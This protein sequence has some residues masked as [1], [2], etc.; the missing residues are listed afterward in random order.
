MNRGEDRKEV[1]IALVILCYKGGEKVREFVKMTQRL[2]SSRNLTYQ[3]V[4]VGNYNAREKESD[5]TPRIIREIAA[6]DPRITTVTLEKKGMFGWDVKSGFKEARGKTIAFIDGDGQNPIEDIVRVYNALVGAG[7]DMAI[8]Y[9]VK[10]HDGLERILVS[11]I[12]NRLLRV[13]FPRVTVYDANA[14]P[15]LFTKKALGELV[16]NAD[17]WFIDAEIVIQAC[18]KNFRIA[19]LPT[20]FLKQSGRSSFVN[21]RAI[22]VFLVAL[23]MYRLRFRS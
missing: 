6:H 5:P 15:K 3:L 17:D 11:R 16:L 23:I 7:A 1:D 14:K 20:V 19:Q 10:R 13:L 22:L 21:I 4:L 18:Y 12:Y 9:R 2:L 8:T